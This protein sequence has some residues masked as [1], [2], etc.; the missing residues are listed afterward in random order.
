[1]FDCLYVFVFD[2]LFRNHIRCGLALYRKCKYVPTLVIVL[3][4]DFLS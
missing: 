4:E 3:Y 1:M 2:H